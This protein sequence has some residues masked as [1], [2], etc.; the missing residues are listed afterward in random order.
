MRRLASVGKTVLGCAVGDCQDHV[1]NL[2]AVRSSDWLGRK[3]DSGLNALKE[4]RP[5]FRKRTWGTLRRTWHPRSKG[6]A[7]HSG[8]DGLR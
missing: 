2:G 8:G 3:I 7:N 6:S 4:L 1:E 5:R